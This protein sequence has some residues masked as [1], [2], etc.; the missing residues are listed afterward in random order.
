[1]GETTSATL[2]VEITFTRVLLIAGANARITSG[3]DTKITSTSWNVCDVK[4][5]KGSGKIDSF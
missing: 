1:M 4:D 3:K 5:C 2:S